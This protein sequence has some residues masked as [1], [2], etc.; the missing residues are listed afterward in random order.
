MTILFNAN[1]KTEFGT[2]YD[3]DKIRNGLDPVVS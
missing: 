2:W 1:F 3:Y